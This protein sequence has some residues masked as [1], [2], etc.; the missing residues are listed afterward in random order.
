MNVEDV[1]NAAGIH[2]LLLGAQEYE[3]PCPVVPAATENDYAQAQILWLREV[4]SGA[5]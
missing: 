2:L 5:K 3:P 1:E 4:A